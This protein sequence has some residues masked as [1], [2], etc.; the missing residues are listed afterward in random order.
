[1]SLPAP[2][3]FALE[4]AVLVAVGVALS[5]ADLAL[6]PFVLLMGGAWILVATGERVLSRPPDDAVPAAWQPAPERREDAATVRVVPKPTSETS[7]RP[8]PEPQPAEQDE[9]EVSQEPEPEPERALEVVPDPQPEP[10]L[11]PEQEEYAEPVVELPQAAHR[12]PEG[13]NLWDLEQRA[14]QLAG[15]DPS[16]DE[17]WIALFVSLR[18]YAR[19]DGTLPHEFDALVAES[20]G[21]LTSR[22]P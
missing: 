10:E 11:E 8:E 17:E 1:M 19:P 5:A 22:R 7:R 13:W 12:R 20:F 16:R 6:L 2:F 15:R 18:D 21:E 4:A 3:R 9:P 14:H